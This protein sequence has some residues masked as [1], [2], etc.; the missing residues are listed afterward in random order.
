MVIFVFVEHLKTRPEY[1]T[2][3]FQVQ[4]IQTNADYVKLIKVHC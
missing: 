4:D 2:M 1:V 3:S